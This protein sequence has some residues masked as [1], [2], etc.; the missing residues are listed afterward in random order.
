METL[1]RLLASVEAGLDAFEKEPSLES[2]K[3]LTV[4]LNPLPAHITDVAAS[5][6]TAQCASCLRRA[7]N[8]HNER[9]ALQ[10]RGPPPAITAARPPAAL[11]R[12]PA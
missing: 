1:R 7:N 12:L 8:S 9:S 2:A 3:L 4:A 10:E 6:D 5:A 11:R